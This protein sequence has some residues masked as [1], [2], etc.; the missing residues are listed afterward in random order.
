M[1][2]LVDNSPDYN[3]LSEERIAQIPENS[4]GLRFDQALT[5]LFPDYS[6]SRLQAWLKDGLIL[7]NGERA[8]AKD[9]V[10]GG[11]MVCLQVQP[12]PEEAAFL[13]ENL[14]LDI[15]FEDDSLL[16][17][18]KPAGL[19][20]HP[21]AGNWTGTLLNALLFHYPASAKLA[22]AGIVHRLD[23]DTTGLMVVAKTQAAQTKLVQ[24]LQNHDVGRIYRAIVDGRVPHDG[25]IDEAIGRDPYNRQKMAVVS[26]GGKRAVTH[27]KVLRQFDF[28]TYIEC[29]LETGRTH[30]IRVHMRQS[31]HPLVGDPL[32]GNPRYR[33]PPQFGD[34]VRQFPRQALHA[35][36]L[37]FQHPITG[38]M[39]RFKTRLPEDMRALLSELQDVQH[40][41]H[42]PVDTEED[43]AEDDDGDW[44]IIYVKD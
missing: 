31:G 26:F 37:Q 19:V 10:F 18:N 13:P 29:R 1:T 39:M 12:T 14:P 6:R 11:E 38:E 5:A 28:H 36:A 4:A 34:M 27:V 7:L 21:A 3:D 40:L 20:V 15:V 23:K 8:R 32:Y 24:A 42:P 41:L 9:R 17:I 16:V 44:E 43:F 30:Q 35:L 25:V 22:R 33:L 2:N